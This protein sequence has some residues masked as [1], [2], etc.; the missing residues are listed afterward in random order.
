[1][2]AGVPATYG[3]VAA[4]SVN[5]PVAGVHLATGTLNVML[6]LDMDPASPPRSSTM[7]RFQLPLKLPPNEDNK[8]VPCVTAPGPGA[9]QV[10]E[11]P[12]LDGL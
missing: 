10:S 11:A 7:N 2:L 6:Q 8:G 3:I 9:T 12:L 1:M 5:N 4:G